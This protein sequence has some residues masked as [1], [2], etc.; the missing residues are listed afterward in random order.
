MGF[1]RV[2]LCLSYLPLFQAQEYRRFRF[3][4]SHLMFFV[5]SRDSTNRGYVVDL[6]EGNFVTWELM[7]TIRRR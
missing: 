3:D 5:F 7:N 2:A 4:P 1:F 6:G